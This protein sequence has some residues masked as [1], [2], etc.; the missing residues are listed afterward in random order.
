MKVFDGEITALE[1]NFGPDGIRLVAIRLRRVASPAPRPQDAHV[2]GDDD[3]PDRP[4]ARGG[5]ASDVR[6]RG[7]LGRSTTSSSRTTR[8][9]T[10]SSSGSPRCTTTRRMV[11][12]GCFASGKSRSGGGSR[13]SSSTG[14]T[15][16]NGAARLHSFFPRA[17]AAQQVNE[18]VVRAWD[19][20]KKEKI[21]ATAVRRAA[22][23]ADRDPARARSQAQFGERSPCTSPDAP[24]R[25]VAEARA[26]SRRASRPTSAARSSARAGTCEGHPRIRAGTTLK[27]KGLGPEFN[28]KYRVTAATHAYGGPTGYTTTFEVMGRLPRELLDLAQTTTK[29][30]WGKSLVVGIVT[31]NEDTRDKARKSLVRVKYPD[32]RRRGERRRL[33]PGSRR[34]GGPQDRGQMMLPQVGDEVLVGFEHGDPHRPYVLG[35]LWNGMDK[36]QRS[37]STRR[38]RRRASGRLVRAPQ[39]QAHRHGGDRQRRAS[40][41]TRT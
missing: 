36:P 24:R 23:L 2:P 40:R 9:T 20:Q 26:S 14:R 41:P 27:I 16:T 33:G 13:W 5:E 18:V 28:G 34:R 15:P 32:P 17:S 10:S 38:N 4:E 31:N 22:R 6:R 39:P 37:T 8:P 29:N 3:L 25:H 19:P 30:T 12:G 21:E 1:P 35:A 11:D 7:D